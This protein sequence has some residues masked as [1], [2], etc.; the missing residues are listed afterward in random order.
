[1]NQEFDETKYVKSRGRDPYRFK[2]QSSKSKT[3][4]Q[5]Q[6][7]PQLPQQQQ[8][9][10]QTLNELSDTGTLS[11]V[12]NEITDKVS[13]TIRHK[14][15]SAL[16]R[17]VITVPG[18]PG[19]MLTAY[20][21][22]PTPEPDVLQ[23][24]YVVKPQR[25]VIDLVIQCPSSPA[26]HLTERTIYSRPHRPVIIPRIV[27]QQLGSTQF[28]NYSNLGYGQQTTLDPQLVDMSGRFDS[29]RSLENQDLYPTPYSST[30]NSNLNQGYLPMG[31][32]NNMNQVDMIGADQWMMGDQYNMT[33]NPNLWTSMGPSTRQIGQLDQLEQMEQLGYMGPMVPNVGQLR[34]MNSNPLIDPYTFKYDYSSP[35]MNLP[36]SSY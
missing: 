30:M 5:A 9:Q 19:R 36:Y 12:L 6:A 35:N 21:R 34:D 8:Q 13:Q 23:R 31:R 29:R 1:M 22:L 14:K 26:A 28:T 20:R 15:E 32:F 27:Q 33:T 11:E 4:P 3:Q 2:Y 16:Y 18:P 7:Q 25:D 10:Q 17:Q 24:V